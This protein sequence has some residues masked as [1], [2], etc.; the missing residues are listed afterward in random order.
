MDPRIGLVS[1]VV[2]GLKEDLEEAR[3]VF[4]GKLGGGAFECGTLIGSRGD[5][6]G[7]GAAD[8]RDQQI[9][10]V[11]NRFTAEV[12]KI[13]AFFL[14]GVNEREGAVGRA[15]SDGFDEFLKSIVGDDA[16]EFA[17]FS[18]ADV[19]AA[20]GAHLLEERQGIAHAA[21]G[22]ACDDT[23]SFRLDVEIFFGGDFLEAADDFGEGERSKVEMLRPRANRVDKIFG[24]RG[25]HHKDDTVGRLFES[26]QQGVGSLGGEHVRFVEDN[27]FVA[28]AG[29]S[30][31]DH[32]AE[33]ANLVDAAIGC[34][35]D[36]DDVKRRASSDFFAGVALTARFGGGTVYAIQRFGEDTRGRSLADT[37]CAGK[38]VSVGD[39]IIANRVCE[40]VGDMALTYEILES[41]R[42]PLA[43]YDLIGHSCSRR[44]VRGFW[45]VPSAS[46]R[47]LG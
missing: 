4:F 16:K 2:V 41:L 28:R 8:P 5:Q 13:A 37:A 6:V 43:G 21:F 9:A 11:T 40:R 22:H 27:D 36:F 20:V 15:G 45:I 26:F 3:Q 39:P 17:N 19:I 38:N 23:E 44:A 29:G 32:F 30:V 33:F 46:A 12:L 1:Q 42:A 14:K 10:H 31:A 7:I 47:N 18:G 35:V 34:G 24:L 25:G